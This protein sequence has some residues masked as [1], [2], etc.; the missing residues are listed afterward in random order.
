M[1]F[2]FYFA[3]SLS[4]FTFFAKAQDFKDV[5]IDNYQF[6]THADYYIFAGSDGLIYFREASKWG[7]M[8]NGKVILAAEYDYAP[9]FYDG[10]AIVRKGEQQGLVDIEG[11]FVLPV[12][13]E[14]SAKPYH[15]SLFRDGLLIVSKNGWFGAINPKGE[16]VVPLQYGWLGE[17]RNGQAQASDKITGKSGMIDIH[18]RVTIPFEYDLMDHNDSGE[19]SVAN[20]DTGEW[21]VLRKGKPMPAVKIKRNKP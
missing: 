21:T 15:G 11:R 2:K 17:F 9:N 20:I 18:N 19:V 12:E 3:L 5:N 16:F 7:V 6:I 14:I 8:R 13:Y 10:F 4:I 1:R